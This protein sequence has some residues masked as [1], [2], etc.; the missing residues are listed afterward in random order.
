MIALGSDHG[1]YELK[2]YIKEHLKKRGIEIKDFGCSGE[3][4]DYPDFGIAVAESVASGE[5]EGG[6]LCCGT[7][8]GICISANKVKGIRAA[9]V[10]SVETARLTKLHNNANIIC[11]GGRVINPDT[12]LQCVDAWLDTEFEGGRHRER[13]NKIS[14]YEERNDKQ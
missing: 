8:I 6:V 11:L 9:V 14:E 1:G 7:G 12:A 13:I 5:F 3:Q 2:E 4:C 10:S